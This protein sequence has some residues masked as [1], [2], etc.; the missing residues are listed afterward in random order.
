MKRAVVSGVLMLGLSGCVTVADLPRGY[1]LG[2]YPAEGI[3]VVSLTLTGQAIERAASFS[4][5]VRPASEAAGEMIRRPYFESA[6]QQGRWMQDKAA[7]GP[8]PVPLIVKDPASREPL[9][10]LEAGR[11]VGRVAVLRLPAGEYELYDWQL[12]VPNRYGGDEFRPK[13]TAIYRFRIEAQRATYLGNLNLHVTDQ[14][15]YRISI[16]D[17]ANRDLALLAQKAP[18]LRAE[19]VRYQP[20]LADPK[21]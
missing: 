4:Y 20:P 5:R 1:T 10:V 16:D 13:Q 9:D 2:E 21:P 11:P 14:D 19:D 17:R 12:R 7:Q 6:L 15:T 8:Q 3:A 18:T